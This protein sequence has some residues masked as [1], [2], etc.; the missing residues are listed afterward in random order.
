MNAA[1]PLASTPELSG[2]GGSDVTL[3]LIMDVSVSVAL[4][5]G[6]AQVTVRE[7]LQMTQGSIIELDRLAGEPLDVF[8]NGVRVAR[9]EVVVVN[10]RFGVR[11]TEV[12]S[13]RERMERVK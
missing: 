7:L 12:V 3:D 2:D 6:R 1:N 8:V 4:E 9:G 11:L 10:E 13:A 5:V